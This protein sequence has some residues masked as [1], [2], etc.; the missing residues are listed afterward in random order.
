MAAPAMTTQVCPPVLYPVC[1]DVDFGVPR[2]DDPR[3]DNA[4]TTQADNAR[5]ARQEAADFGVD[6]ALL[7]ADLARSPAERV[8]ANDA[9]VGL[10]VRARRQTLTAEQRERLARREMLEEIRAY[11]FD[12]VVALYEAMTPDPP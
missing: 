7:D 5:R 12:E 3:M 4:R 10:A 6:L 2:L 11:G 1:S 9:L 8:G